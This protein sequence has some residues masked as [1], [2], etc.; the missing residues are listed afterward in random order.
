MIAQILAL[1]LQLSFISIVSDHELLSPEHSDNTRHISAY[2]SQVHPVHPFLDRQTFENRSFMP[3]LAADLATDASWS[4]LYHAVIALGCQYHGG[5]AFEPRKGES[6]TFYRI[7]LGLFPDI[8][9]GK[10]T[11]VTAQVISL[12]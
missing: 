6:W 12:K 7:A 10:K 11:L 1:L 9:I 2:F 4:A 8:L 3:G 5:A